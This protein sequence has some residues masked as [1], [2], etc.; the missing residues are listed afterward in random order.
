MVSPVGEGRCGCPSNECS[1]AL[2]SSGT[3]VVSG[4]GSED[5]PYTLDIPGIQ[6]Y[7]DVVDTASVNLSESGLGIPGNPIVITG[8]AS[9]TA[10]DFETFTAD[11]SYAVPATASVLFIRAVGGGG[12]G[13]GGQT[14]AS[15]GR[16]GGGGQGG[17]MSEMLV[18]TA[19]IGA[20]LAIV[21]GQGGN[22]GTGGASGGGGGSNGANGTATTVADGAELVTAG[23]YGQGGRSGG[24]GGEGGARTDQVA[25]VSGGHG[26]GSALVGA[27][28]APTAT[29]L[30]P[31]GGGA[32]A[33][34]TIGGIVI[35]AGPGGSAG[36]LGGTG[37]TAGGGAG[38]AYSGGGGGNVGAVG[39]VG[40][41]YGGG[42]GGGGG[43]VSGTGAGG[44][45]GAGADGFVQIAAW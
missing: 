36:C 42:G 15:G 7:A 44:T 3:V 21:I 1:C 32:G 34:H 35:A 14:T 28:G 26:K 29:C 38:G 18:S 30:S 11:G 8:T 16:G 31:A 40:G 37:G 2:E 25:T 10:V 27:Q 43:R 12:G 33:S 6:A 13:G 20:S 9:P 17:G 41:N 4:T 19:D 45:G 5:D 39:G 22:G 24:N 23:D